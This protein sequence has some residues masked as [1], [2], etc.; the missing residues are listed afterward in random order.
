MFT[1]DYL[2]TLT[3]TAKVTRFAAPVAGKRCS[4]KTRRATLCQK[5][6]IRG[7]GR[8]QL[9]GGPST[10]LR[11]TKGGA[12]VIVANT[13]HGRRSKTSIEKGKAI[14]I[15][16]HTNHSGVPESGAFPG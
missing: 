16:N 3:E 15:G 10:G 6:T 7:R 5:L 13:K 14:G 11:A 4:A 9:H 1:N 8:Y 12:R 2:A